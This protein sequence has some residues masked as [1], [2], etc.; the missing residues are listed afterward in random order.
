M[1]MD[2]LVHTLMEERGLTLAEFTALLGYQSKTSLA[3]IM[4][5]QTNQRALD[6]FVKRLCEKLTLTDRERQQLDETLEYMQ[7]QEDYQASREMIRFLKGELSAEETVMIEDVGTHQISDFAERYKSAVNIRITMLNCQFISVFPALLNYVRRYD[8]EIEH[9]L[10]LGEM[11]IG[12]LKAANVMIP[13]LYEARFTCY[14]LRI[15]KSAEWLHAFGML[16]SDV[17]VIHYV[18]AAGESREDLLVF[19][20]PNHGCVLSGPMTGGVLRLLSIPR[21]RFKPV[22]RTYGPST[23]ME[24]YVQLSADCAEL[25]YNRAVYLLKPDVC[26]NWIPV[27][28]LE[29]ALLAGGIPGIA[30]MSGILDKLRAIFE[31]RVRNAFDKR[32]ISRTIL[33]RGAMLRFARTGRMLDHFWGMRPFTREERVRILENLLDQIEGN[34]Y[35]NVYFLKDNSCIQDACI[36]YYEDA[37]ILILD[38]NTDYQ[39][40]SNYSEIMISHPE[41]MRLFKEYFERVLLVREVVSFT[42]TVDFVRK[43]IRIAAEQSESEDS[44]NSFSP[45]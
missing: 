38:S 30:Q 16:A 40:S 7:W 41:F 31:S 2:E 4:K 43:L 11:P 24:S 14:A 23:S 22:K 20:R 26:I 45:I 27:D 34:P 6:T 39:L 36:N 32:K 33:K 12:V 25:E 29:S 5:N 13:L 19:D 17:M 18:D 28:I 42:E 3:R 21:D 44:W 10:L 15:D 37:G 35:F 1:K 8:A 9:F